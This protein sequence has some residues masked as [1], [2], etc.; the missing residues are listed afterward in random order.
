MHHEITFYL[1]KLFQGHELLQH[2]DTPRS[3]ARVLFVD[4][5]S[6]F[7][8]IVPQKL[9]NKLIGMNVNISLCHWILDFLL[10][11]PQVVKFNNKTSGTLVLNT[12]APQGSVLSPLLYSLF[13]NDCVTHNDSV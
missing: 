4:Y 1:E 2:L 10:K 5:S 12:G 11:R 3:Y 13:T 7:N 8:T 9:F 6:A